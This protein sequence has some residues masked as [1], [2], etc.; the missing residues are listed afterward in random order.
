MLTGVYTM[1]SVALHYSYS[2]VDG[3]TDFALINAQGPRF[4][5]VRGLA[6]N[7]KEVTTHTVGL[8]YDFLPSAAFKIDVGTTEDDFNNTDTGFVRTGVALVF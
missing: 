3:T 6:A 1:G 8:R 5:V 2:T 4:A 7:A